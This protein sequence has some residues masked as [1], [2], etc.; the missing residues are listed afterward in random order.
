M[1]V[2]LLSVAALLVAIALSIF[3]RLN[4]G[5]LGLGFAYLLGV[6]GAGMKLREV[7]AGFPTSLL[8]TLV[9]LTLLFGHAKES[10][11]LDRVAGFSVQLA[12]GRPGMLPIVFFILAV[13]LGTIG[14]GNIGA[15]ALLAPVGMA[16]AHEAGVPAFL[17]A[18]MVA[19]GG[20]AAALSP[21]APTGVIAVDLMSRIGLPGQGWQNY[22]QCLLAHTVVGFGGY[23]SLGGLRLLREKPSPQQLERLSALLAAR[24]LPLEWRHGLTLSVILAIL[25]IVA[26]YRIDVGVVALGGALLLS[27]LRVS[28]EEKVIHG[29]PWSTILMVCG[30][31]TLMTILEKTGGIDLF[32][33]ALVRL[34]TPSTA[35]GV[36]GLCTGA[37]SA[38]SSSSGVVLPAFLPIIP[39]LIT[40]LGGGVPLALANSVNIGA[41]LVDVSPLSTLGALCLAN[42][43]P[44]E[45][46]G[47]LYRQLLAWGLSMAVV[48][49]VYCYVVFGVIGLG[50]R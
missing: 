31:T 15:V 22:A 30:M 16:V 48:G 27:V 32:T 35:P 4:V 17:M 36:M 46:T 45:D 13:A 40:K 6:F 42:A 34:S 20:N 1:L 23:L 11:T 47:L 7:S 29:L 5:L 9:G 26:S 25:I 50:S 2:P 33:R 21:V 24:R 38:Y 8:L 14:A 44:T 37:L 19:C 43:A 41:H 49:A 39:G 10:G 3:S 28:D 12:R 18:L